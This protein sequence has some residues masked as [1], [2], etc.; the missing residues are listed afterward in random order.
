VASGPSDSR[1]LRA[2]AILEL[3]AER[4]RGARASRAMVDAALTEITRR[5]AGAPPS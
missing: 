1:F 5:R 3:L 2:D 4:E